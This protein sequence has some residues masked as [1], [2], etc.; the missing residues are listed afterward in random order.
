VEDRRVNAY[1]FAGLLVAI[2][3]VAYFALGLHKHTCRCHDDDA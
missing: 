3:A 1:V 2:H